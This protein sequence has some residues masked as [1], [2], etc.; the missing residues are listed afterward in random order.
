MID[1]PSNKTYGNCLLGLHCSHKNPAANRA[2]AG[3]LVVA[4]RQHERLYTTYPQMPVERLGVVLWLQSKPTDDLKIAL[5]G[6]DFRA[7]E[8]ESRTQDA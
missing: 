4:R 7:P 5:E 3:F 2:V 1:A 8:Q 6:A